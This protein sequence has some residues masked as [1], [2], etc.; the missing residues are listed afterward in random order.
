MSHKKLDY[1]NRRRII[2]RRNPITDTPSETFSWGNFYEDGTR[3]CYELF[4]SKAKITS[5]RS[6]K[7]HLLVLW[8]LNPQLTYDDILELA[9]YIGDKDN[10]FIT[11]ALTNA[12]IKNTVNEVFEMDLEEPPKI[13]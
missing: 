13:K 10:G 1:L 8:Y 2:Y 5:Y 4:R 6:F 9:Q 3:E 11:V 12:S 7:W